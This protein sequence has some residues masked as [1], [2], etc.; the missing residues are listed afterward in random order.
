MND[1]KQDVSLEELFKELDQLIA[2]ME[3][4][5]LPLDQAF[6]LY[7]SGIKKVKQCSEK[8]D[9]IEKKML[10]LTSAGEVVEF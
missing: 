4:G 2:M 5:E 8:L 1:N 3:S 6:E 7:E 10:E 9:L